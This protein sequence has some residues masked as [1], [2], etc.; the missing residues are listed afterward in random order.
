MLVNYGLKGVIWHN[1]VWD[2]ALLV[3]GNQERN[4]K[5]SGIEIG[6]IYVTGF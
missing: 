3:A 4:H 5:N 1:G 6:R 2:C